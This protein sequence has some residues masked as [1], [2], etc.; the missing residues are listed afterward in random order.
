MTAS[1]RN[2][3]KGSDFHG[4]PGYLAEDVLNGIRAEEGYSF[5]LYWT[6]RIASKL[7]DADLRTPVISCMIAAVNAHRQS[8]TSGFMGAVD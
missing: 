1:A 8:G 6:Q 2:S 5:H 7:S 4:V 3:F